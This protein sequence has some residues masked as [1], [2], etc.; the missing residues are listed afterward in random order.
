MGQNCVEIL[1]G[2]ERFTRELEKGAFFLMADWARRFEYV[3]GMAF[4]D[5]PEITRKIFQM[6][7]KY[8]LGLRTPRSGD[9]S[10][11]AE[12]VSRL[13]DLPL[14]WMDVGLD[15]LEKTLKHTIESCKHTPA[16][17]GGQ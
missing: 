16:K 1:L 8:L 13:V 14:H 2:K 12:K 4:N 5:N 10:D 7:H 6:E 11:H 3:T 9:F 17:R 15:H